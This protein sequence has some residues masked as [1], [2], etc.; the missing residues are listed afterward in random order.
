[1]TREEAQIRARLIEV[2]RYTIDLDLT[3]GEE[4]FGSTTTIRFRARE[5]GADTFVELHPAALHRAVLDGRELDLTGAAGALA[6]G[7][8]PL[9]AL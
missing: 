5:A 7:R 2:H 3:R 9:T 6:D 1:L 4:L 8:L